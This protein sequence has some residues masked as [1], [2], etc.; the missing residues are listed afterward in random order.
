VQRACTAGWSAARVVRGRER[1]WGPAGDRGDPAGPSHRAARRR[2]RVLPIRFRR[3]VAGEE[4]P[5]QGAIGR[6]TMIRCRPAAWPKPLSLS[7]RASWS[8][9]LSGAERG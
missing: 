5:D 7:V 9:R 8:W 2:R 1:P 6:V 3:C 4:Q